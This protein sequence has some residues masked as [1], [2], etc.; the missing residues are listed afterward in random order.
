MG[1]VLWVIVALL[2]FDRVAHA[3]M[4]EILSEGI[5]GPKQAMSEVQD[6]CEARV[7]SM[8]QVKT[9]QEWEALAKKMRADALDKVVF[10]GEAARWRDYHGK[11]QWMG[12][13]AG[14]EGYTIRK[15]RYEAVPGMWIP[16]G[17]YVPDKIDGKAPAVLNV[18]GHDGGGKAVA[19]KQ[20]NCINQAK[21]GMFAL[22]VEW[23][24]F[25]Q[26]AGGGFNHAKMNQIDLC[27]TSGIAPFYLAMAR[28][29]DLLESLDAVDK[30]RLAV[31]GLSGGGWQTI[32]ISSLD[33]RVKLSDPV[34]GYSSF[35]TRARFLE[36]LGD[37]EQTP[38]DLGTVA[39]YAHLTAMR[40]PRPTLL[41]FNSKDDCCFASGHALQ[42]LLEAA[43]P[44]FALYG[45]ENALRSH[46]N[47]VPGTHNYEKENREEFYKMAGDFF[48]PGKLDYHEIECAGELKTK[49][50]LQVEMPAEN[51]DFHSLAMKL[52]KD[53]PRKLRTPENPREELKRLVAWKDLKISAESA[54][55]EEKDG[56]AVH[57]W[58]LRVELS[59][60][61][62][63]GTVIGVHDGGRKAAADQVN[64][65]L[66]DGKRVLAIDPFYF[67]ESKIEKRD[68][69]YA[70][71][72][73][74]IGD[75]PLGLQASQ[76]AAAGRWIGEK[77]K[78]E[79]VSVM[80][81]G[82]RTS[83]FA[84]IAAAVEPSIASVELNQPLASLREVIEKDWTMEKTPEMFC[85]GL[86]GEFDLKDIL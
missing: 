17:L 50:Q 79:E 14:G 63:K 76:L 6:Y 48:F 23:F 51:Q 33:E 62:A 4:K 65:L 52:S 68:Y 20:I 73:L 85:F 31:T 60:A 66:A 77:Y 86:L 12:T 84:L 34:A 58:K 25:G 35:K 27:G 72:M 43:K 59:R 53:L 75:R 40:A 44:I 46:V 49:E 71:L 45:A 18:T 2:I 70:L 67:G 39:D 42:P 36:D 29:L 24:S 57:R 32:F 15:V 10:R 55:V 74:T 16:A 21:R 61:G 7:P 83:T 8:P 82:P 80:A 3:D 38:C 13:I 9:K 5:I 64:K 11:P 19:Y 47:D 81:V 22:N 26:L 56:I 30:D 41:T 78:G 54:G 1:R 37:S 69:L 28:G